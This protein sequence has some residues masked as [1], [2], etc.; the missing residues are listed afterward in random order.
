MIQLIGKTA[1]G[2][3][4]KCDKCSAIHVEFKNMGFNLS[5]KQFPSFAESILDLDDAE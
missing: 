1:N 3:I 5:E 2:K 4:F